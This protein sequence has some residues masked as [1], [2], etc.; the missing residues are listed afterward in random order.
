MF[1]YLDCRSLNSD[2][3][4]ASLYGSVQKL[5]QDFENETAQHNAT[6][7][8]FDNLKTELQNKFPGEFN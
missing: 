8:A 7:Q 2:Q 6:K 4:I 1:G 3:I 5:I